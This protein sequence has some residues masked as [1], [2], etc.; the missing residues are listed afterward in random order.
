[1]SHLQHAVPDIVLR[2]G[3]V[4][5][6]CTKSAPKLATSRLCFYTTRAN[7]AIL[8]HPNKAVIIANIINLWN[9]FGR[10]VCVKNA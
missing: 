8:P 6:L 4:R 1:L 5:P 2:L 7:F 9:A 3:F 10:P